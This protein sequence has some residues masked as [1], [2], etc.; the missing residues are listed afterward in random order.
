MDG[1]PFNYNTLAYTLFMTAF[2]FIYSCTNDLKKNV[3]FSLLNESLVTSNSIINNST[4]MVYKALEDKLSDPGIVYKARIWEPKARKIMDL[5]K[6]MT[7]YIDSLKTVAEKEKSFSKERGTELY[8]KL[9]KYK[10]DLMEIDSSMKLEFDNKIV[11]TA[12]S[13][14]SVKH[15]PKDFS[16]IFF[17][18]SSLEKMV[19][20][21]SKFQNNIS[22][23]ENRL[24]RYCNNHCPYHSW[25]IDDWVIPFTNINA[26]NVK[27][28][29]QVRIT[30]GT[31]T[32]R[33][34]P[35]T[36]ISIDGK[37]VPIDANGMAE[38]SFK[39][40]KLGKYAA[41]VKVS[42]LDQDAKK[43]ILSKSIEYTVTK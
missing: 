16:D 35:E 39:A 21:L 3:A 17:D 19:S 20:I 34:Y 11:I 36:E 13:F 28:G 22:I 8:S 38:Y 24:V 32:F 41:I 27:I 42:Y 2:I 4:E 15:D 1:R 29:N 9:L 26:D 10:G 43:Q 6:D 31:T 14:D 5:S 23:T 12:S 37:K 7:A 25:I 18:K 33:K 40:R 30:A